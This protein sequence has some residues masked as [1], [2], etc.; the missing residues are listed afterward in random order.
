MFSVVKAVM[1]SDMQWMSPKRMMNLAGADNT[2]KQIKAEA[3]KPHRPIIYALAHCF[4][5]LFFF[6]FFFFSAQR[7]T[8][9]DAP[10]RFF[11]FRAVSLPFFQCDSGSVTKMGVA[12][13]PRVTGKPMEP[14]TDCRLRDSHDNAKKKNLFH[15]DSFINCPAALTA[16]SQSAKSATA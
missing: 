13:V 7:E 9:K 10:F 5:F 11:L 14:W 4:F 2:A 12:L 6:V 15:P 16:S 1:W 8:R 3:Q